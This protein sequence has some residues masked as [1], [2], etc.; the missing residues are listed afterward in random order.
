LRLLKA[1]GDPLILIVDPETNSRE[2]L[3]NFL[4]SAGYRHVDSAKGLEEALQKVEESDYYVVVLNA[5]SH[6]E[7]GIRSADNITLLS[8][9]TKVILLVGPEDRPVSRD[10][11]RGQFLIKATFS[12]D[13][14]YLLEK[15]A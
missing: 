4:L 9:K 5:V 7:A 2:E 13:L 8:P 15:D 11:Y 10:K 1:T 3:H 14:L 12:R 6:L